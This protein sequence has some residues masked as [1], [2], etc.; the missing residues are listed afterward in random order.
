MKYNLLATIYV[1]QEIE[2]DSE[3]TAKEIFRK[4]LGLFATDPFVIYVIILIVLIELVLNTEK[5]G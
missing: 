4:G 3:E 1:Q 5:S 2:A